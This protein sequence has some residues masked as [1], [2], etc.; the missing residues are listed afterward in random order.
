MEWNVQP[1]G[2][3]RLQTWKVLE[4]PKEKAVRCIAMHAITSEYFLK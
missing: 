3:E 1:E 4:D 2:G